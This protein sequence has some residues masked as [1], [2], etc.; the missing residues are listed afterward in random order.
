MH[1]VLILVPLLVLCILACAPSRQTPPE[2]APDPFDADD[3][4]RSIVIQ[5]WVHPVPASARRTPAVARA[6]VAA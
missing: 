5:V 6:R 3:R 4:Q 2:P 1:T